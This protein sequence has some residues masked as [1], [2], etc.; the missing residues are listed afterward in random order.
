MSPLKSGL[1]IT[2]LSTAENFGVRRSLLFASAGDAG[3]ESG[4]DPLSTVAWKTPLGSSTSHSR[5]S[6][7][8]PTALSTTQP[9][10]TDGFPRTPACGWWA[11]AVRWK[12]RWKLDQLV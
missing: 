10:S 2:C 3:G 1:A 9:P 4:G 11:A 12:L 8:Y 7:I 6:G 5:A